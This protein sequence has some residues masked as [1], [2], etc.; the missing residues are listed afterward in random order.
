[1]CPGRAQISVTS[2]ATTAGREVVVGPA[3]GPLLWGLR[4]ER[5]ALKRGRTG[6]LA[7]VTL[8]QPAQVH[9]RVRRSGRTIRTLR[10]GCQPAGAF[11]VSWNGNGRIR[12]ARPARYTIEVR[13]LSDRAP[14]VRRFTMLTRG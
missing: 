8:A 10:R 4:V 6:R 7:S 12:P 3:E 2:G 5:R 1:V 14:I 13:V 11:P 9:V